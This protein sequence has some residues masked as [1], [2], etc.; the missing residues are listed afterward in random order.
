MAPL[1]EV[2]EKT[3]KGLEQLGVSYTLKE[4]QSDNNSFIHVPSKN[5]YV[6]KEK[7]H[8]EKNWFE[9][10][11]ELQKQ[12]LSMI[13]IPEFVEFLK[14]TK[15]D[16]PEIYNEITEIRNPWRAEWLDAFFEKREDGMYVLTR[17][18]TKAEKLDDDTLMEDKRISLKSWLNHPTNQGLPR[19]DVNEGGLYYWYPRDSSVAR[20]GALSGRADLSCSRN[21]RN[22]NSALGVRAVRRE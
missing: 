8:F 18:K 1:I 2:S 12:R 16:F 19:K 20:F 7:T 3:L 21:P 14:H 9:S 22:R 4:V 6:A 17:N 15:Y 10:H 13:P 5:L 11:E